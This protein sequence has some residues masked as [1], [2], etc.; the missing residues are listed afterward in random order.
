MRYL[1]L[2]F[3]ASDA[4]PGVHKAQQ[5]SELKRPGIADG[6]LRGANVGLLKGRGDSLSVAIKS[7]EASVSSVV[8][9]R[10]IGRTRACTPGRRSFG[11]CLHQARCPRDA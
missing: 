3:K 9:P 10:A 6:L 5:L 4:I 2:E 1:N 7:S 11:R 8:L